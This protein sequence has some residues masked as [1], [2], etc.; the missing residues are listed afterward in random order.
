MIIKKDY[1]YV[2]ALITIRQSISFRKKENMKV[3]C[4]SQDRNQD[5]GQIAIFYVTEND[6]KEGNQSRSSLTRALNPAPDVFP[7][8]DVSDSKLQ[9]AHRNLESASS[10]K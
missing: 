7:S 4:P 6:R 2:A 10:K 5:T 3:T 1:G 9:A 8:P